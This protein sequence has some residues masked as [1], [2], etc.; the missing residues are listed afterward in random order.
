M[1][2]AV[3]KKDVPINENQKIAPVNPYAVSK[4]FQDL[5]SQVYFKSFNLKIIITRMFSYTNSR[6]NNLFIES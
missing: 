1:Y 3:K 5:L 6:R 4:T 2:G